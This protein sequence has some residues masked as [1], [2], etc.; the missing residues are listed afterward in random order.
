MFVRYDVFMWSFR[1]VAIPYR[2]VV[3][4]QFADYFNRL[5]TIWIILTTVGIIGYHMTTYI[6]VFHVTAGIVVYHN[7]FPNYHH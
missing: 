6:V 5:H 4:I 7:H 1:S 2:A 3:F